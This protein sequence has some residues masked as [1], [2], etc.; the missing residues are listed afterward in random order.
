MELRHLRYFV[1]VAELGSFTR[2]SQALFIAQPP[3]SNQIRDLEAEIGA[4]LLVRHVRGVTLTPAGE[5]VLRE[6][7]QI[8]AHAERLKLCATQDQ[9]DAK[10]T[11]SIGFVPSTTHFLLPYVL[12]VLRERRPGL[13]I[14]VREMLS[15]EQ[16]AA[17]QTGTLDAALC[18]PP[19]RAKTLSIAAEFDDPFVL[20]IPKRH[21]LSRRG[22]IRLEEAAQAD[23]VAFKRDE[24]RAFFDQTLE[25]CTEAGFSPAIRCE[26]GTVFGVLN[27]V[28]AGIGVAIVPASCASAAGENVVMRR[29]VRPA[30]PGAL[31][32]VKRKVDRD[33]AVELLGQ[34]MKEAFVSLQSI[35]DGK[36]Q[37]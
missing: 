3:L 15:S 25:F 27:L 9:G 36:L 11:L 16:L 33:P 22:D 24:A 10:R 17:V 18:R 29:L 28:A 19:V 20:A 23:F 2:A 13:E 5:A 34:L 26:A 7:K 1:T 8:L 6:A 21:V 32:L 30:R 14:D 31:L 4:Q 12:P 35:V 37:G